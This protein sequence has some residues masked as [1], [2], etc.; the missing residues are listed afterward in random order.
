MAFKDAVKS[1]ISTFQKKNQY[2][3]KENWYCPMKKTSKV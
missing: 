1:W 2:S 3:G